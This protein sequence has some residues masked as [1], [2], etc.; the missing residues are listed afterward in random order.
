MEFTLLGAIASAADETFDRV[1]QT[2]DKT[3]TN[4]IDQ[5][6]L[7]PGAQVRDICS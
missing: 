2:G 4:I 1:A 5:C 6:S 3:N 7:D